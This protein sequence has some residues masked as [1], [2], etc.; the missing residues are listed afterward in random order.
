[1]EN[2]NELFA[3]LSLAQV[4]FLPI[5]KSRENPYFKSKYADLSEIREATT[6]SLSKHGLSIIQII[7]QDSE[8]A[9]VKTILCH[10]SGQSICSTIKIK[11]TKQDPQG[12]G[13]AI[14]YCRRYGLGAILGV[15]SEDDDDGNAASEQNNV[16]DNHGKTELKH[17]LELIDRAKAAGFDADA[18]ISN[19]VVSSLQEYSVASFEQLGRQSL[20][21]LVYKFKEFGKTLK[22]DS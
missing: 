12:F 16:N 13:S 6:P 1:M 19:W 17:L 8:Y 11:P 7:E 3:A 20:G 5:K 2:C 15:A 18:K 14:T 4:E 10:K 21:E 9:I 22:K